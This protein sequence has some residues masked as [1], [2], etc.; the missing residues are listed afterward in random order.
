MT[1]LSIQ[2]LIYM[3]LGIYRNNS[4]F[5]LCY[6]SSSMPAWICVNAFLERFIFGKSLVKHVMCALYKITFGNIYW[7]NDSKQNTQYFPKDCIACYSTT[8]GPFCN[9]CVLSMLLLN[10]FEEENQETQLQMLYFTIRPYSLWPY[11][12]IQIKSYLSDE[13]MVYSI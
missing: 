11:Q 13:H 6:W 3:Y 4:H 10:P 1:F 8:R 9:C 12:E 5:I 2:I 7:M